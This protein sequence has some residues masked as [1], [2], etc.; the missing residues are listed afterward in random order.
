MKKAKRF[1]LSKKQLKSMCE[2]A[3]PLMDWMQANAHPHCEAHVDQCSVELT[4][5]VGLERFQ[6]H[7]QW[8]ETHG[9]AYLKEAGK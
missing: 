6:E 2:A 4:E 1:V 8:L 5:S 3:K 9:A 7:S